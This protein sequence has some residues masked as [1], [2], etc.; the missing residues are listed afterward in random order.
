M[1]VRAHKNHLIEDEEER[2]EHFASQCSLKWIANR[3]FSD[4]GRHYSV[5]LI[6]VFE[7]HIKESTVTDMELFTMKRQLH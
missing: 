7:D 2:R 3:D 6:R 4:T 1:H 5:V